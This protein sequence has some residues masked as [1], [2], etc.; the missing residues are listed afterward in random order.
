MIIRIMKKQTM[1]TWRNY[2]N[3]QFT[4]EP[5]R[6]LMYVDLAM[7]SSSENDDNQLSLL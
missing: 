7:S 5:L 4:P 3:N 1:L 2:T 6:E